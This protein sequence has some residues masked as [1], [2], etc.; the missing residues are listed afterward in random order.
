MK[1]ILILIV[2]TGGFIF[3]MKSEGQIENSVCHSK[4]SV[5][6]YV[7]EDMIV[8][9]AYTINRE[10]PPFGMILESKDKFISSEVDENISLQ[11]Y[12]RRV[13]DVEKV[14][15]VIILIG[16]AFPYGIYYPDEFS[17]YEA[18]VGPALILYEPGF[19]NV[20]SIDVCKFENTYYCSFSD[21]FGG[22]VWISHQEKDYLIPGLLDS[23][24]AGLRNKHF[25]G[26]VG[27]SPYEDESIV[28]GVDLI[29]LEMKSIYFMKR[30]DTFS[31]THRFLR[32]IQI[33]GDEFYSVGMNCTERSSVWA[34][35]PYRDCAESNFSVIRAAVQDPN[36]HADD[37]IWSYVLDNVGGGVDIGV[38]LAEVS[39][40]EV[41]A[42]GIASRVGGAMDVFVVRLSPDG[43]ERWQYR[44]E[45]PG[46]GATEE[47]SMTIDGDESLSLVGTFVDDTG[48]KGAWR[49][50]L[51]GDGGVIGEAT[52]GGL[53]L[54][55]EKVGWAALSPAGEIWIAGTA[56]G[57]GD[58]AGDAWMGRF[59][60]T[61]GEIWTKSWS[62]EPGLKDRLD[63]ATLSPSGGM[64]VGLGSVNPDLGDRED[65]VFACF[66]ATGE[67][68]GQQRVNLPECDWPPDLPDDDGPDDDAADDD[69]TDDDDDTIPSDD[70]D[71]A[72]SDDDDSD[73][74]CGC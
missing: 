33:E 60:A 71:A 74:C 2:F 4:V 8:S 44:H 10:N 11:Y 39:D 32:I 55:G 14:F 1:K 21:Y 24:S 25:L 22:Y 64:C 66:D 34:G 38:E 37:P 48:H 18:G 58:D 41:I 40:G 73:G 68:I 59:D 36:D 54:L 56:P 43:E 16:S 49:L 35:D 53:P 63:K 23:S 51:D 62:P 29:D 50:D 46:A 57:E 67:L 9:G 47:M 13:N 30:Y 3:V 65:A 28:F 61:G 19:L 45:L 17:D 7:D 5:L 31:G 6:K 12:L 26:I 72:D 15:D 69:T 52:V 70:D 42:A 27:N 20:K